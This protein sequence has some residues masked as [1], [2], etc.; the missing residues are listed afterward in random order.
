MLNQSNYIEQIISEL[1]VT[2]DARKSERQ[3]D[4]E[5]PEA[6]FWDVTLRT[7]NGETVSFKRYGLGPAYGD[8]P[9]NAA[10]VLE[11]LFD[12]AVSDAGK[13]RGEKRLR[14]FIGDDRFESLVDGRYHQSEQSVSIGSKL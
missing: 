12:D 11:S 1:G 2:V 5:W 14:K 10:A 4:P 8:N 9:P 6:M 3:N 7:E 13:P